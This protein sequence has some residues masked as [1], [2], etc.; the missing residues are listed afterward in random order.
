MRLTRKPILD[1]EDVYFNN[2]K[3]SVE[4]SAIGS[5]TLYQKSQIDYKKKF[6]LHSKVF[7]D[8]DYTPHSGRKLRSESFPGVQV[9]VLLDIRAQSNFISKDSFNILCNNK[10]ILKRILTDSG[11]RICFAFAKCLVAKEKV[12]FKVRIVD[13]VTNIAVDLANLQAHIVETLP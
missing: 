4:D 12:S 8:S 7:E 5:D 11:I 10:L 13:P 3:T 2:S 1:V 6:N 9:N